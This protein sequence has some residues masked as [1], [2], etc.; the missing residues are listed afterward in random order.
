MAVV[1]PAPEEGGPVLAVEKVDVRFGGIHALRGVSLNVSAGE[2]CGLIGPNGA[3][4][5]TLFNC[6]TRL[7]A[8]TA[9][10]IRLRGQT[11]ETLPPRQ[12]IRMG[13]ARTFQ[14]LGIYAGM[15]VLEN[16]MLG[17][18][19]ISGGRFID[20]LMR[21]GRSR[22]REQEI[23]HRCREILADL[24]LKDVAGVPAGSLPYATQK[25]ME[26]ARALA[27]RP[28]VLLLDEPA[29]GLTHGEV[30][31]FGHLVSRVRTTYGV[32]V[33]LIEHHM[34]L[35]MSLCDRIEVFHLGQNL[36][37]GR[38]EEVRANWAVIDAYLGRSR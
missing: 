5:T 14:N 37:R 34:G 24:D 15:T 9:G 38:P 31:E 22:Q 11:I 8:V 6:I 13:I 29:G 28:I 23:E 1:A 36:A 3:G 21:P 17:A 2:I 18:H 19:H 26:I 12:I 27:S 16:V 25:R 33:V 32:T 35:V 4:K 7:S 20:A 10:T 30:G